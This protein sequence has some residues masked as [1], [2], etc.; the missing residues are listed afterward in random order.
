MLAIV[1][2]KASRHEPDPGYFNAMNLKMNI[3]NSPV[4]KKPE[5]VAVL[6]RIH[7]D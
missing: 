4:L 3:T 5:F 2:D 6:D 7:G 1:A